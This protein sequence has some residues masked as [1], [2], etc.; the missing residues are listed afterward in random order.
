[1]TAAGSHAVPAEYQDSQT[2]RGVLQSARTVAVVGL[3]ENALRPSHFVGFY[4]QRHGYTVVPVNP[5]EPEV[6]GAT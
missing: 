3:S 1:M 6:L 4:L 2:I 5:R